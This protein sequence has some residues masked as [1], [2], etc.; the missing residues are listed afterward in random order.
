MWPELCCLEGKEFWFSLFLFTF[1]L[2]F[3]C[4]FT[5]SE[6]N[7]PIL[8]VKLFPHAQV[9]ICSIKRLVLNR[10][11]LKRNPIY[12]LAPVNDGSGIFLILR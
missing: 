1:T 2:P 6:Y 4:F 12:R 3:F 9:P 7:V 10:S 8:P 5:K 11:L